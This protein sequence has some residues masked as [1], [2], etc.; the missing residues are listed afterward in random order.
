M[1]YH[2]VADSFYT[3]KRCIRLFSSKVQFFIENSRFAFLSP[4]LT[5]LWGLEATTMFILGSLESA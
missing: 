1:P 3:K 2:F 4:L 5:L